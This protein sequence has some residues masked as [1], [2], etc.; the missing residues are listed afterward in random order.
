MRLGLLLIVFILALASHGPAVAQPFVGKCVSPNEPFTIRGGNFGPQ[1][2]SQVI[3]LGERRVRL[4][5]LG[6]SN[7][8]I[9]LLLPR[10]PRGLD[11]TSYP[12]QVTFGTAGAQTIGRITLCP[13][14]PRGE[15]VTR[16][17]G[18]DEVAAPN[19]SPEYVV[20]VPPS[21]AGNA[22]NALQ[23]A[24]ATLLR[25]RPLPSIGRVLLIV[26]LPP[27]LPLA[28]AAQ[29]LQGAAPA[30]RIDVH[31]I[32]GLAE[33]PRQFAAALVG[34]D[35]A[36]RCTLRRSVRVGLI[37]GPVDRAHPALAGVPLVQ[38][39]FLNRGQRP[40]SAAHGTGIA[41]LIGG[42]ADA[43][44]FAGFASGA[45]LYAANAFYASRG[46]SQANLE[47]VAASLDWLTGQGVRLVN[48]SFAGAPN[49]ALADVIS[50]TAG[51]G[52]VM[53]ASSG[54]DGQRTPA[55]PAAAPEVI[56]VTAVDARARL[57]NRANTGPHIEFA[58]P[59]VDVFAAESRR[60]GYVSGTSYASAIVTG[61][62]ARLQAQGAGSNAI[63][64]SLQRGARD[65]GP[66]GRDDRFGWGL[67][68]SGGC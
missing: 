13:A 59:G 6:W 37:D 28:S 23:Q 26:Q 29:I 36:R 15:R 7:S 58:A 32:Y 33:G 4:R 1:P 31:R 35:P 10:R 52:V 27:S 22:Q 62:A 16:R 25:T 18:R 47:G 12:I 14:A 44:P 53:V 21:Q 40:V 9:R 8:R 60:G 24:G 66:A 43:G 17:A 56:A 55:F 30:A 45:S 50:A 65:L 42:R 49:A 39:S 48:M 68:S 38:A 51:Q 57:Y 3:L 20:S 11:E 41:A 19:R 46:R 5:V 2:P 61:L 54:N 67:I 63:R 64:R 34:D